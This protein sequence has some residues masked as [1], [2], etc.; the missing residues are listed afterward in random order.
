M[1]NW[2]VSVGYAEVAFEDNVNSKTTIGALTVNSIILLFTPSTLALTVIIPS[3][4]ISSLIKMTLPNKTHRSCPCKIDQDTFWFVAFEGKIVL[5][6]WIAFPSPTSVLLA[7]IVTEETLIP[8]FTSISF[9]TNSPI[10]LITTTLPPVVEVS[11]I[12]NFPS[13]EIVANELPSLI[14]YVTVSVTGWS[15]LTWVLKL[16]TSPGNAK[17]LSE[18][19]TKLISWISGLTVNDNTFDLDSF[20]DLLSDDNEPKSNKGKKDRITD[21]D[22]DELFADDYT[23]SNTPTDS[24]ILDIQKE[25]EAKFDELFGSSNDD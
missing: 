17:F 21:S 9:E 25:L 2:I 12:V 6:N 15:D 22:L 3:S 18:V 5:L 16:T 4:V 7:E 20:D 19:N 14:S 23:D 11:L 10:L 8:T 24:E 13:A 1:L